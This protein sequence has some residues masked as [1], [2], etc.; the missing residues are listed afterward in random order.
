MRAPG[1]TIVE[2][3]YPYL[4]LCPEGIIFTYVPKVFEDPY[5][6]FIS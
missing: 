6:R 1:N 2:L 3:T 5:K 4:Y